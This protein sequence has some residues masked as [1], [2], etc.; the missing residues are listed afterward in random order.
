[1]SKYDNFLLIG[2]FDTEMNDSAMREF[3]DTYNL[4]NLITKP[5][6]FKNSLN[7]RLIDLI[8]IVIIAQNY[9]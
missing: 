1:M 2:D 9:L 6:Y 4:K 5:T 3:N 7:P 8:A